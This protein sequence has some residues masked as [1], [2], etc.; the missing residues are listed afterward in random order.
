MKQELE[1]LIEK[2]KDNR[3]KKVIF[4]SHCILNENTRYLGGAFRKSAVKE[5]LEVFQ[6]QDIGIIQLPCP[7]Q[8]A[9]GGVLKKYLWLGVGCKNTML[10]QF[11]KL[12][13][14]NFFSN[15]RRKNRFYRCKI[16]TGT[17]TSKLDNVGHA[18]LGGWYGHPRQDPE[19]ILANLV[20]CEPAW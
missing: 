2:L 10:Y 18:N 11:R 3:S 15:T 20:R 14:P 17:V 12:I 16:L 9:W 8:K 6:N 13:F 1:A 4:V 7:E 19:L 5:I